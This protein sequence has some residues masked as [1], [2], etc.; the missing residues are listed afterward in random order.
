MFIF[1]KLGV[2]EGQKGLG[3]VNIEKYAKLFGIGEKT[4]I[5]LPDEKGGCNPQS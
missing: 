5:D 2:F 4:K 1:M 3:I